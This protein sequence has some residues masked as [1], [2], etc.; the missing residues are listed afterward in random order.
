MNRSSFTQTRSQRKPAPIAGHCDSEIA[1]APPAFCLACLTCL[2]ALELSRQALPLPAHC[3]NS[4]S[5]NAKTRPASLA[6]WQAGRLAGWQAGRLAGW[7]A[8]RLAD[9]SRLGEEQAVAPAGRNLPKPSGAKGSR[10]TGLSLGHPRRRAAFGNASIAPVAFNS[11]GADSGLSAAATPQVAQLARLLGR[12]GA[13]DMVCSLSGSPTPPG[14]HRPPS[15][16]TS[17]LVVSLEH[18]ATGSFL[19]AQSTK[20][21]GTKELEPR[22]HQ[23]PSP[24]SLRQLPPQVMD[25]TPMC[26]VAFP[27]SVS[28]KAPRASPRAGASAARASGPILRGELETS[29]PEIPSA[30]DRRS[31]RSNGDGT[32]CASTHPRELWSSHQVIK[33]SSHQVIK[34]PASGA[35]LSASVSA[36]RK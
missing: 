8:G 35:V 14:G 34:S 36:P 24:K 6:G 17:P 20:A 18:T 30:C 32:T 2:L 31:A 13:K 33:S 19:F 15:S 21:P 26:H 7:Q 28:L 29:T 16:S 22:V 12:D 1:A 23:A 11:L 5:P 10:A 27:H 4:S 9:T 25:A 3:P